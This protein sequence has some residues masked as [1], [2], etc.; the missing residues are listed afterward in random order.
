MAGPVDE[1]YFQELPVEVFGQN[2][3]LTL[4]PDFEGPCYVKLRLFNNLDREVYEKVLPFRMPKV[5]RVDMEPHPK[6]FYTLLI[7]KDGLLVQRTRVIK[8]R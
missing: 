2:G 8:L 6:G 7:E 3:G 1:L 5:I 4:R